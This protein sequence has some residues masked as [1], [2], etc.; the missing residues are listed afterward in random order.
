MSS[1]NQGNALGYVQRTA[2]STATMGLTYVM[3]GFALTAA[4]AWMALVRFLIKTY[5]KVPGTAGMYLFLYAIVVTVLAAVVYNIFSRWATIPAV[6]I[7]G[8]V[9]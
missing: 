3:L 8:V 6:P 4:L 2:T 5:V 1:E 7:I 9:G